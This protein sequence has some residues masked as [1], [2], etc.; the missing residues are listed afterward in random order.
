MRYVYLTILAG[1]L[2]A[3]PAAASELTITQK[4]KQ[5]DKPAVTAKV[6]DKLVFRNDDS[7]AHNVHSASTGHRF[8]LGLQQPGESA[9]LVL[10]EDGT[11]LIRCAIH[12]KM[13]LEVSVRK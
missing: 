9:A 12:P 1:A 6:G 13:K 5:F 10:A 7:T 2:A 11:F 8:D 3:G 4:D